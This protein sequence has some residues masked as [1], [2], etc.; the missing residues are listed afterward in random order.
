M[1]R[2]I[3]SILMLILV[4]STLLMTGCG[5]FV[6]QNTK[7]NLQVPTNLRV[8]EDSSMLMWNSVEYASGYT[9]MVNET[10][11]ITGTNSFSL[12]VLKPGDYTIS[13]KANG[14]GVMYVS[15]AYSNSIGYK[16]IADS[17]TEYEDDVVAAFREF[18]EINTKNSFLGYGIDIINASAITSKNV[19]MTYPIFDMDKLMNENLLKSNEHYNSFEAIEA[20]TIEAFTQNMSNSTSITAGANVSA[21]GSYA[22]V[23]AS[24][25]ASLTSGLTTAFTKTSESVESQYFLEIIAENQSYWLV[26]Q[27]SEQRYKD[28]LS[29]E[30]KADLYNTA[31][32]PAQLFMKYGTHMLTSVAMG[33]N[34]CM[35]YTMY[36]YDKSTANTAYAE[37]SSTL[38]TNVEVAYG[39]ASAG[40]GTENSF[41]SAYSY[42]AIANQYGIHVDKKIVS[43]GGGS[44][45]INNEMTLYENYHDW[46]KSLDI[47]PVVIGVKDA[48]SLYPIWNLLD[49]NVEGA[50]ERY[51][52]LYSYFQEYGEASYNNLCETYAITP[53]VAPSDISNITVG[54]YENYFEHQMVNVKSG[55][56]LKISFDVAPHNANKYLK[57]FAV[58]KTDLA[59]IDDTGLL[60]ISPQAPGGSYIKVMIA[61]GPVS[62]QITLYVTNTYNV[63]FNTRVTGLEVDSIIGILEG[64]TIEAPQIEREGWVL[65][66]WYTDAA[67]TNKF[68]FENDSVTSHMTLYAKWVAI[69]PIV[70][71]ETGGGNVIDAQILAYCGVATKPKDPVRSGYTFGGW[72][73]DEDC[74]VSFDFATQITKDLTLYAKWERNDFEVTFVTNGGTPIAPVTTSIEEAYKIVEP[75]TAK[76]YYVLDGWYLD[77]YFTQKFYFESEVTKNITLYANWIPAKATVRFVDSDGTSP[78]Y[79]AVGVIIASRET[80]V[81]NAFKIVAPMP[82]K[83]GYTFLGWYLNGAPVDVSAHVEFKPCEEAYT[84]VAKWSINSYTITFLLNEEE[85][86]VTAYH[87]GE[88][89]FYPPISKEGYTFQ[90]WTF[91]FREL[92]ETMPMENIT[93]SGN[94][95]VNNH[96]IYYY[97]LEEIDGERVRTLH[98]CSDPIAYGMSIEL[99]EDPVSPGKAFSGWQYTGGS[100][101]PTTMP[102]MDLIFEGAYDQLLYMV[103]YYVNG[104]L[105]GSDSVNKGFSIPSYIPD[106][107]EGYSFGGWKCADGSGAPNVMPAENLNLY[108]SYTINQYSLIFKDFD[109]TILK[110]ERVDYGSVVEAP[111][112]PQVEGYTDKGWNLNIP[113]TMPSQDIMFE[114]VRII[115]QY[116]L[117][118]KDF[119]GTILK[120]ET[121]DYGSVVVA[122]SIPAVEGYT[123]DRWN[124]VLPQ[125]MPAQDVTIVAE[126]TI[127]VYSIRFIDWDGTVLYGD[128]YSNIEYGSEIVIPV[129]P[130]RKG[131]TFDGW[132]R[133]IPPTMPAE[134]L[135]IVAQYDIIRCNI[136]YNLNN[137]DLSGTFSME[138]NQ[139][140]VDYQTITH[141]VNTIQSYGYVFDGWYTMPVNGERLTDAN[142]KLEPNV[143]NYTDSYG[144]FVCTQETVDVYAHWTPLT[145]TITYYANGGNGTMAESIHSYGIEKKITKNAFSRNSYAFL[146]WSTNPDDLFPMYNDST[147]GSIISNT[148]ISLY[149][150]WVKTESTVSFSAEAGQRDIKLGRD[151]SHIETVASGFDRETLCNHSRYKQIQVV[152]QLDCKETNWICHN[153]ARIQLLSENGEIISTAT[154]G[155]GDINNEWKTR[156][157]VFV[158]NIDALDADGN[159]RIKYS[160]VDGGGSSSDG[161]WLGYTK[162]VVIA[163]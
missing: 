98:Y 32:T 44:F 85:Y 150:I 146:G 43:A 70:T 120:Q 80:D 148:D 88:T 122:P 82:E 97:M 66:G 124:S 121:V 16:R 91:G 123:F 39:G 163:I 23:D 58:D 20:A 53:S 138:K 83:A 100:V 24:A 128:E 79:D 101:C 90:G 19:L 95:L 161:W 139:E 36:S 114:V 17:G 149:A 156:S 13:V 113:E 117:T 96:K 10:T 86:A 87:F 57:T 76:Q 14:D 130:T 59:T 65:E 154:I 160:T 137:T 54:S 27:T 81:E 162:V 151:N 5:E 108:G 106:I 68:D 8:D 118:F 52:E 34:I 55:E 147:N 1:K 159:L 89:I 63:T 112:I 158:I 12:N 25:S 71:F 104:N 61:A 92:P 29:E 93:I 35:Y 77:E 47:Y 132:D 145:Y 74:T 56:T 31:I 11:F 22:G 64:Y 15:S 42:Q 50:S 26:L 131:Y 2:T 69:K 126:R 99:L 75:I 119:D 111:M 135:M 78:V 134:N 3:A 73:A 41:N 136:Y 4:I 37:V 143:L 30:F 7:Q 107:P 153:Y 9:V 48:N 40:A 105:V 133:E 142:G 110:Q 157:V 62:K 127:Q 116:T 45:G 109:G 144:Q 6:Q 46:Q 60:V 115:N 102:D 51:Q 21:K 125:T 155:T 84:L 141:F 38:K 67:N 140:A 49:L 94:L 103:C 152:V 28:L 129:S 18:D 72:Y 33:G